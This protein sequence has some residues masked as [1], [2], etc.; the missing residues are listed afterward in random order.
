VWWG[1]YGDG[2]A[3]NHCLYLSLSPPPPSLS[4]SLPWDLV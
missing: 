3:I 4:P 1:E 2:I